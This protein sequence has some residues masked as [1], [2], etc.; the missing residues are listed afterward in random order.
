MTLHPRVAATWSLMQQNGAIVEES[1][2]LAE[3]LKQQADVL[4]QADRQ[5]GLNATEDYHAA[6]APKPLRSNHKL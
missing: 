2:A 4:G 6:R 5:F 1:A 3:C